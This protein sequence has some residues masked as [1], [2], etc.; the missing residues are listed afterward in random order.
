MGDTITFNIKRLVK[1]PYCGFENLWYCK[2]DEEPE[3]HICHCEPDEGGC[4][5]SFVL[6]F[7]SKIEISFSTKKIEGEEKTHENELGVN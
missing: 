2:D 1:C 6:S 5:R 7:S 3:L 4:D